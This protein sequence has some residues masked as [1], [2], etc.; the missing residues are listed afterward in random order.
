MRRLLSL[1]KVQC[2]DGDDR[3]CRTDY[4]EQDVVD[5]QKSR[6]AVVQE[7]AVRVDC[8]RET[9]GWLT[10]R[11]PTA[12]V[13]TETG[14]E[15]CPHIEKGGRQK[16]REHILL[17]GGFVDSH[18]IS[19]QEL[20]LS[21][22][23]FLWEILGVLLGSFQEVVTITCAREPIPEKVYISCVWRWE[24]A[25]LSSFDERLVCEVPVT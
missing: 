25:N 4:A 15:P 13:R 10:S 19:V 5:L 1:D 7:S 21:Y 23:V 17:C 3:H 8:L 11:V 6:L 16:L 14:S 22:W 12:R 18:E 20:V 9:N 24:P 2:D